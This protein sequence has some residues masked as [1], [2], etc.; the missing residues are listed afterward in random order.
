FQVDNLSPRSTVQGR[1]AGRGALIGKLDNKLP[2]SMDRSGGMKGMET[3]RKRGFELLLTD[4]ARQAFDLRRE[5]PRLRERYGMHPWG[6]R[7]LSARRLVEAG[8][9]FVTMVFENPMP[10][11]QN[12][13][14][15]TTYNW[16]SHAVNC[17][18]FTDTKLR[19]PYLDQ[20]VTALIDDL[21]A[22]GLDRK[23]L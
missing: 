23:V 16:D 8:A 18:I 17:H 10:R 6:Q 11:G 20:A 15:D 13:L 7:A 2:A 9:S 5:S 19:L 22:R 1:L 14:K 3:S 21:Y 12:L 4:E